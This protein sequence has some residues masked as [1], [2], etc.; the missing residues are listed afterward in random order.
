M[1]PLF[2]IIGAGILLNWLVSSQEETKT[3]DAKPD[4]GGGNLNPSAANVEEETEEI[5]VI[6]PITLDV[7]R[8]L[9]QN[10]NRPLRKRDAVE[11]LKGAPYFVPKTNSYRALAPA[12]RFAGHL[13]EDE[14][15][16]LHFSP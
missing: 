2:I 7:L 16:W 3:P 5:P 12:R 6:Q 9:F 10:G 8:E 14:N 15:G 11:L 1:N 4:T 13:R